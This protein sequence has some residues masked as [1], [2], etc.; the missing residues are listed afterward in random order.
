MSEQT[1][2]EWKKIGEDAGRMVQEAVS[3]GDYSDLSRNMAGLMNRAFDNITGSIEQAVAGVTG[4]KSDPASKEEKA[5]SNETR[6]AERFES[7]NTM[8]DIHG[9]NSDDFR[10][11]TP[12]PEWQNTKT[13]QYINQI[14]KEHRRKSI[15][16][17]A[18]GSPLYEPMTVRKVLSV[19]GM[20]VGL[21][22]GVILG[23]VFGVLTAA[24]SPWYILPIVLC[25]VPFLGCG[26]AGM[27]SYKRVNR[28]EQYKEALNGRDYADISLL[29]QEVGKSE[30]ATIKDLLKMINSRWFKEGHIDEKQ[31]CL[32]TSDKTYEQY[33]LTEKNQ[34]AKQ[35]KEEEERRR[36]DELYAGLTEDQKEIFRQ[37]E[38]YLVQ[39]RQCREEISDGAMSE[40][41][42]RME[43]SVTMILDQ[44][45]KQPKL[46]ED[47]RRLMNY[48]LP[49]SIKLL[50]AYADFDRQG[51]D[52]DTIKR[53]KKEIEDTVDTLNAA[54]DKLFDNMF[55]DTSLDIS[56]D[57]E[58][59]KTLLAQEGLTGHQFTSETKM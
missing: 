48:Y 8:K 24:V 18:L 5:A 29:A 42:L 4:Q 12:N 49:T 19:V 38:G 16:K 21:P 35:E 46:M 47:L 20:A 31:T 58:V 59:M 17:I 14:H 45:K 43:N 26:L 1:G 50:N 9:R 44:A 23:G 56:T 6:E 33:L 57:A 37:G 34:L 28:F 51:K 3:S 53:S 52:T 40:K 55:A 11:F 41:V 30:K 10:Q 22:L 54:F 36:A 7:A 13:A 39:I 15:R 2:E 32:I 25:A 27:G